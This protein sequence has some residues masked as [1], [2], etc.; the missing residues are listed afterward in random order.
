MGPYLTCGAPR[1]VRQLNRTGKGRHMS[2]I[3][4]LIK[5]LRIGT[6][7]EFEGLTV[8]PL[9]TETVGEPGYVVLDQ[10]LA[11][12][13][14]IVRE[15]NEEG[16][17]PELALDNRSGQPI[18]A[19]DGEELVGAKQNRILNLTILAPAGVTTVIPVSCVEAG[20]WQYRSRHFGSSG[21]SFYARGKAA[22]M[23]Q[24]SESLRQGQS[25][26]SDQGAIWHDISAKSMRMQANSPTG[27]MAALY[28]DSNARLENYVAALKPIAG[29]V[30]A[31][32]ATKSGILGLDVFDRPSTYAHLAAK[33]VRSN[34]L[35]VLDVGAGP[36]D[37]P[38]GRFGAGEAT[39][40]LEEVSVAE[41]KSYEAVG[42]GED[43]RLGTDR[44]VGAALRAGEAVIHFS[45]FTRAA[46]PQQPD[47]GRV[48]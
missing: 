37:A 8:T 32:F 20:R 24:V 40:F 25:R 5:T 29:M 36:D 42:L 1:S 22:K 41:E 10:A 7:R 4:E 2:H 12:G 39:A 17:V 28:E 48:C 44:L 18:L 30:G 46:R 34:A 27:A 23:A 13:E 15:V 19:V 31:V 47:Y 14:A 38:A 33:L 45:A 26:R 43:L 11:K 35:E 6:S 3:G 16:N 9:L 21:R